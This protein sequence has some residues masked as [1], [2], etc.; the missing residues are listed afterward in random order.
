M[1]RR[2]LHAALFFLAILTILTTEAAVGIICSLPLSPSLAPAR[3]VID[4]YFAVSVADPYRYMWKTSLT[5]KFT[6]GC[7]PRTIAH[8]GCSPAFPDARSSSPDQSCSTNRSQ[9]RY[10]PTISRRGKW[11]L[12]LMRGGH[13]ICVSFVYILVPISNLMLKN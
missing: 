5:R 9:R 2:L 11:I 13:V 7:R 8:V 6:R 3:L 12:S 4:H 10:L 1:F